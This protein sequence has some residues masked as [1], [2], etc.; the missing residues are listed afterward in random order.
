MSI[1]EII[2]S[3]SDAAGP[4]GFDEPVAAK[5]RDM[6]AALTDEVQTDVLGNVIGVKRCGRPNAKKLLFD[7]HIDEIG[8]IVTGHEDGFL[9]FSTLGGVNARML[10]ASVVKVLTEPPL[11]GVVAAAPPHILKEEESDK[12]VKA[13]DLYIDIGISQEEAVKAVPLGT[14]AVY[15]GGA[16]A[17]G[18]GLICG[19]GLDDRAC[20]ASIL[21]ALELLREDTLEVDLYVLASVQ[22]E[23]AGAARKRERSQSLRTG[24]WPWTRIMPKRPTQRSIRSGRRAAASLSRGE[25]S[26]TGALR[27][28]PSDWPVRRV[29]DTSWASK[30]AIPAPT[31]AISRS[32]RGRGDGAAGAAA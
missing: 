8:F 3:L 17:L 7:A 10:P 15:A 13:E 5:V 21:R 2:R 6:L 11:T 4:A 1:E 26:S 22:E 16:R 24:A 23:V 12:A 20:L 14:P 18:N 32:P 28:L 9:R 31:P 30:Q 27:T 25:R 29:S 19:K